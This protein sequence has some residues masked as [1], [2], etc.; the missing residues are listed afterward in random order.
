MKA[1][2]KLFLC[3]VTGSFILFATQIW[4]EVSQEKSM[5]II[6]ASYNNAKFYTYNLNKWFRVP[7]CISD[8]RIWIVLWTQFDLEK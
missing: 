2:N 6:T 3:V 8:V 5:V 4:P 1:T 7:E